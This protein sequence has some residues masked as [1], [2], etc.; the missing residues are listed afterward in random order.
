[1]AALGIVLFFII[2]IYLVAMYFINEKEIAN[3]RLEKKKN[4][5]ERIERTRIQTKQALNKEEDL[6][7]AGAL[8]IWVSI[9]RMF[10]DFLDKY[11]EI[12]LTIPSLSAPLRKI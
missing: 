9:S 4:E 10:M 12:T 1:M 3:R 11:F 2:V 8:E 5:R 7:Y 6:D